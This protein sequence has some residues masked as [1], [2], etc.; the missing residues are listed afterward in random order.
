MA[1]FKSI[2]SSGGCYVLL[3]NGVNFENISYFQDIEAE[4][5]FRQENRLNEANNGILSS[6]T[7][8]WRTYI[9]FEL[10]NKGS[11]YDTIKTLVNSINLIQNSDD[12]ILNVYPRA[13]SLGKFYTCDLES[14]FDV[15]DIND[16]IER[17]Q[18]IYLTFKGKELIDLPYYV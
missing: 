5:E 6:K 9:S 1:E 4:I 2:Y 12:R 17:G 13:N 16:K 8:G 18:T 15:E 11:N 7:A 14:D 10:V 3:M